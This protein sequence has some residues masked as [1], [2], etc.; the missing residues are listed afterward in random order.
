MPHYESTVG[1]AERRWTTLRVPPFPRSEQFVME[2]S[3][4]SFHVA[5]D[6]LYDELA[7]RLTHVDGVLGV[8]LREAHEVDECWV[9]TSTLTFELIRE[10]SRIKSRV[11]L[12]NDVVLDLRFAESPAKLPDDCFLTSEPLG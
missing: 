12:A 4:P 6:R 5:D 7:Q 2:G 11:E 10:V 1:Q 3:W 8:G 9:A